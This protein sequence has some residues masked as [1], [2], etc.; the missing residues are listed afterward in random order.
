MEPKIGWTLL[1]REA[2]RRAEN[3]L[4]D[5]ILGVRDEI[6]F[7]ALHQAYADRFFPGTSVQHTRLRYFLFVPWLYMD[8]ADQRVG[9]RIDDALEEAEIKV[10]GR[11]KKAE[12]NRIIGVRN[13]PNPTSQ[14]PSMVYWSALGAWRILRPMRDG[15]HLTRSNLHR[16]ISRAKPTGR[17]R[18]DDKALLEEQEHIFA[19]IPSPP[20][21]WSD[22]T[23]TLTFKITEQER[24]FLKGVI[25]A[26]SRPGGVTQ[27][28]P[29]LLSRLVENRT[30]ITKTTKMW[31]PGVLKAADK[32]DRQALRRAQKVS[33]L[34]AIGRGVYAALVEKVREKHDGISTTSIHRDS[35]VTMKEEY[36]DSAL[37]LDI[38]E[39]SLDTY[40]SIEGIKGV[41]KQTQSWLR[42]SRSTL[43]D[44]FE[45]YSNAEQKR[46]GSKRARLPLTLAAREKRA[47]WQPEKHTEAKPLHYRWGN[48]RDF[49]IDL[50]GE[51]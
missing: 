32:D 30:Q 14:P 18:D 1:S 24:K 29:S 51:A 49:L 28:V 41:L 31:S 12:Q 15:T 9:G 7:L 37:S 8:L 33:H 27:H 19:Q 42:S 34:A 22:S 46:K 4:N 20:R 6:G 48:V 36:R 13:Y 26:L 10:T 5:E 38:D 39:I 40:A 23:K 2:L 45:A 43:D 47:E 16:I 35:L 3:R 50:G 11:L 44:L 21:N 25:L 17:L